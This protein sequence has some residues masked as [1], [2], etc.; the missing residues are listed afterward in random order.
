MAPSAFTEEIRAS[1]ANRTYGGEM[2]VQ[3]ISEGLAKA[4]RR[5]AQ[6]KERL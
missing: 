6:L 4:S 1:D 3:E 5:L 2:T